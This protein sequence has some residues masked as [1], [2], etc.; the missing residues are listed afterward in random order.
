MDQKDLHVG[1][2]KVTQP[3]EK[4]ALAGM[5]GKAVNRKDP[6]L[7]GYFFLE[8]THLVG[9]VNDLSSRSALG[10]EANKDDTG[11]RPPEIVP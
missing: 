6:R 3:I 8:D 4:L 9:P 1:I 11:P 5:G 7:H 10:L 2:L